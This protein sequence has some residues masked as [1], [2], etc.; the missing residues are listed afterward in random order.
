MM[1]SNLEFWNATVRKSH[2]DPKKK[3]NP[4][5]MSFSRLLYVAVSYLLPRAEIRKH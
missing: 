1:S 2:P 4:I 3:K 5:V